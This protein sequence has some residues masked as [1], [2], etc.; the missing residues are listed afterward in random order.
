[1]CQK[2]DYNAQGRIETITIVKDG[3]ILKSELLRDAPKRTE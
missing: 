1:M 2:T 3:S